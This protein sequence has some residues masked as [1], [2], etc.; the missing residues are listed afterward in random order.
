[1]G[2]LCFGVPGARRGRFPRIT[3]V[4]ALALQLQEM[5]DDGEIRSYTDLTRLG[6]VRN[7]ARATTGKGDHRI[8][9]Y[10]LPDGDV[11]RNP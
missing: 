11:V 3:Q 10:E 9:Y 4:L 2:P 8:E 7:L 6:C 5:I 1:M